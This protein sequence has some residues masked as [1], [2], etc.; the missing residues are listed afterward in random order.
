MNPPLRTEDDRQAILE[1]VI[2]RTIDAICT[3]HA[4]HSETEKSGSIADAMSG[5][6]GLET[7]LGVTLTALYHTGKLSLSE[8]AEKMSQKPAEILGLP[9]TGITFGA[10]ADLCIFDPDEMW[11]VDPEKFYSKARNTPFGGMEL[12]GRVRYTVVK[13]E[14]VYQYEG[15]K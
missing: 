11:I 15:G 4:P 13:G 3:D 10:A 14:I 12:Q 8:I 1:A 7:A 9:Y 6:I 5:M 2:D